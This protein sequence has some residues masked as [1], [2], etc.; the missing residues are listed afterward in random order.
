M[1]F[2]DKVLCAAY[3][4][5]VSVNDQFQSLVE[6]FVKSYN[7]REKLLYIKTNVPSLKKT[8]TFITSEVSFIPGISRLSSTDFDIFLKNFAQFLN[9]QISKDITRVLQ[10]KGLYLKSW[11]S[12]DENHT[13]EIN[14]DFP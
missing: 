6:Y 10:F 13:L 14:K 5:D 8:E 7:I 1:D 4:D 3:V 9:L 12:L 2:V 11:E